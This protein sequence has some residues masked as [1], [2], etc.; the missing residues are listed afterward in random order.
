TFA[1]A[2]GRPL[3]WLHASLFFVYAGVEATGTVWLYSFFTEARGIG[4]TIAGTWASLYWASLTAGRILV[5]FVAPL[6]PVLTLQRIAMI[7]VCGGATLIWLADGPWLGFAGVLMVGLAAAPIY[8]LLI[9]E[10]PTRLGAAATGHVVGL[11]VAAAYLG[12]AVWP[13]LAGVLARSVGLDVIG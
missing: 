3:A 9:T 4:P 10:T 8:P 1:V 12:V 7:G 2:L 13:G 5:G 11:Q 6:V